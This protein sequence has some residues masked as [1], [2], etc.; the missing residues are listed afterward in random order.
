M[1]KKLNNCHPKI[2]LT[3]ETNPPNIL[4]SELIILINEVVTY[5]HRKESKLPVHWESKVPKDYK[6]NTLLGELHHAKHIS[7]NSQKEGKNINETFSTA[8]FPPR[9]ITRVAMQFNKSTC[10]NNERNK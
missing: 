5:V 1:F 2:K 3:I 8:N 10:N 4:D 9:F 7:S 6:C